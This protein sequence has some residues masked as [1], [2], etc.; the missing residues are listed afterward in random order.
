MDSEGMFIQTPDEYSI[1]SLRDRGIG[2]V[3]VAFADLNAGDAQI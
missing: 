2:V 3:M 1:H